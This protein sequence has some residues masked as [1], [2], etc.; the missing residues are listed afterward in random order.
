[1]CVTAGYPVLPDPAACL[2]VSSARLL[3]V[4]THLSTFAFV[5]SFAPLVRVTPCVCLRTA[6]GSWT[7]FNRV[8]NVIFYAPLRLPA[9]VTDPTTH[10]YTHHCLFATARS[11]LASRYAFCLP[12]TVSGFT[13][14]F[15]DICDT[16]VHARYLPAV[17]GSV[18]TF[19]LFLP[20]ALH[21]R[22]TH[23]LLVGPPRFY[24]GY[25]VCAHLHV[26]ITT[27]QLVTLHIRVRRFTAL[28]LHLTRAPCPSRGWR[29][30]ARTRFCSHFF[31]L[32]ASAYYPGSGSLFGLRT[33][34]ST[35]TFCSLPHAAVDTAPSRVTA[36]TCPASTLPA[37]PVP[38]SPTTMDLPLRM[39][40]RLRIHPQV[41]AP[42]AFVLST[43]CHWICWVHRILPF[44]ALH[45]ATSADARCYRTRFHTRRASPRTRCYV[46]FGVQLPSLLDAHALPLPRYR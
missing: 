37:I 41:A 28:R 20:F 32:R 24:T 40:P 14:H 23:T 5:Y 2:P 8:R 26:V 29:T 9:V 21:S 25:P 42:Y 35:L 27:L 45:T 31:T 22:I 10:R 43:A 36:P 13:V 19:R 33:P 7:W 15:L 16:P 44:Y 38:H 18:R 3:V 4:G 11:V 6:D 30:F 1:M 46:R 34:R 39:P 17:Y 12:R